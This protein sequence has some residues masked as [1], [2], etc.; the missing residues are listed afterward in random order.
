MGIYI[1]F[2][3]ATLKPIAMHSETASYI[4]LI[5]ISYLCVYVCVFVCVFVYLSK[6]HTQTDAPRKIKTCISIEWRIMYRV[7]KKLDL[8]T[9]QKIWKKCKIWLQNYSKTWL[10]ATE[11]QLENLMETSK[12]DFKITNCMIKLENGIVNNLMKTIKID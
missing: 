9:W 6:I 7:G 5:Y 3:S 1:M 12:I 4:Y 2:M 8:K 10:R 11:L